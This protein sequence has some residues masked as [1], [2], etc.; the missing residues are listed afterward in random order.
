MARFECDY[1]VQA[2]FF[3]MLRSPVYNL[4]SRHGADALAQ[5]VS[6]GHEIAL[7]FDAGCALSPGKTLEAQV[8]FELGV[9]SELVGRKITAFSFHQPSDEV[10]RMRMA[11]PG[12]I[13]T[14]NTDQ[15]AGYKYISDSNRV[16]RGYDPFQLAATGIPRIHILLHPVWWM[17]PEAGVYDCWDRAIQRNLESAQSQLL[18]TERAYGPPRILTL[19]RESHARS[20]VSMLP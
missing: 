2:T 4:M 16:W 5:L 11:L 7:H 19:T 18:A 1:G 3:V 12:V 17:C 14:Y 10:I 8:R 15:L 20:S 13:N 6:L 9:L